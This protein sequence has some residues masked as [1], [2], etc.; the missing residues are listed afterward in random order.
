M[1]RLERDD[2]AGNALDRGQPEMR[3]ISYIIA[4]DETK[5]IFLSDCDSGAMRR[6][7]HKGHNGDESC[8]HTII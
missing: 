1:Q 3:N 4:S 6:E 2:Q 8:N 5:I 7:I